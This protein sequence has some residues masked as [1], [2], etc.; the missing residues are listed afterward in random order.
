MFMF[1]GVNQVSEM[2]TG[3]MSAIIIIMTLLLYY[4]QL[5][6]EIYNIAISNKICRICNFGTK[7]ESSKKKLES[8]STYC[9]QKVYFFPSSWQYFLIWNEAYTRLLVR[10][11]FT[12]A[13]TWNVWGET[14]INEL[15]SFRN[16]RVLKINK[17]LPY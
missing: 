14:Y 5:P 3:T 2:I 13:R 7:I 17:R 16:C 15:R 10:Q 12:L 1:L 8:S 11:L 9:E 6:L 4:F